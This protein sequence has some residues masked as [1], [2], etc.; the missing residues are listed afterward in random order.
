VADGTTD[1]GGS[2]SILVLRA[3]STMTWFTPG[4]FV[5]T[6]SSMAIVRRPNY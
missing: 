5:V 1:W 4:T 2:G 6:A 3:Q